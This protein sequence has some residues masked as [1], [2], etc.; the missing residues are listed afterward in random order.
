MVINDR[1]HWQIIGKIAGCCRQLYRA[2][3]HDNFLL[4]FC[5]LLVVI[6]ADDGVVTHHQLVRVTV[7]ELVD[8]ARSNDV[9]IYRH[10]PLA[11]L[12]ACICCHCCGF[13]IGNHRHIGGVV[14]LA[15]GQFVTVVADRH[16]ACRV[17]EA[18]L[19][20]AVFHLL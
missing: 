8:V 5:L 13:Y 19:V 15:G 11:S 3:I 7:S 12:Q 18:H 2:V 9:V 10:N 20:V 14:H 17:N 1:H 4:N 16:R 6:H